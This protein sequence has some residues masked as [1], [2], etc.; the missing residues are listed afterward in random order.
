MEDVDYAIFFIHVATDTSIP[1]SDVQKLY[2]AESKPLNKLWVI[3]GADH[4][5]AYK[6]NPEDYIDKITS[7]FENPP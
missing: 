1:L 7:F 2:H 4:T 6:T 5:Q 3:D